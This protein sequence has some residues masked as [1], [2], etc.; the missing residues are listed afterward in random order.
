MITEIHQAPRWRLCPQTP[1]SRSL[2][3][4]RIPA[5]SVQVVPASVDLAKRSVSSV[6][7]GACFRLRRDFSP[8]IRLML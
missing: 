4:G 7:S 1:P 5:P 6:C 8:V 2:C 3:Q